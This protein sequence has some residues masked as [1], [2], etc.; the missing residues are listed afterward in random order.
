MLIC[1]FFLLKLFRGSNIFSCVQSNT[2]IFQ[3]FKILSDKWW[4]Q[5][6][7]TKCKI[8]LHWRHL[9]L[10][11]WLTERAV[12]LLYTLRTVRAG[13]KEIDAKRWRLVN[14]C[15][16]S[17]HCDVL[18]I[19]SSVLWDEA[20]DLRRRW[21][22]GR[23]Q[24]GWLTN[25]STDCDD[26]RNLDYCSS[27]SNPLTSHHSALTLN[28]GPFLQFSPACMGGQCGWIEKSFSWRFLW[29]RSEN[30]PWF[31]IWYS[32]P[33]TGLHSPYIRCKFR[34]DI[35]IRSLW[36]TIENIYKELW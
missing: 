16:Q 26:E 35:V 3:K 18:W 17:Y 4:Q 29:A 31:N 32:T 28:H 7:V 11:K 25:S 8:I 24:R 6:A 10:Y 21:G 1:S 19:N 15:P 33:Y 20:R 27:D 14:T 12:M 34:G 30:G 9:S 22:S 23:A 5:S 2:I 13:E 36:R